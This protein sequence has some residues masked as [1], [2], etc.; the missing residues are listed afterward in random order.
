LGAGFTASAFFLLL[1]MHMR[2]CPHCQ[3]P[4][5]ELRLGVRLTPLKARIFDLVKRGGEDGIDRRD[6]CEII[7]GEVTEQ[8]LRT[9]KTH[10]YQISELIEDEG[11]RISGRIAARLARCDVD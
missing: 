8:A 2:T 4:L 10:C 1:E 5:P 7:Y 3:Q 6:L 9:L 11:Y